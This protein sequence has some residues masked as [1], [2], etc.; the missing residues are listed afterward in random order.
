MKKYL[1][2]M[3]ALTGLLFILIV[4][5]YARDLDDNLRKRG[6]DM[7]NRARDMDDNLRKRGDDMR[8][9]WN[10]RSDHIRDRFRNSSRHFGGRHR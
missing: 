2:M 8:D 10:D 3:A 9:R 7:R 1:I 4:P 6:D 5:S